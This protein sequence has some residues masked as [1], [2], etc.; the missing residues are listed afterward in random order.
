MPTNRK[1]FMETLST[2]M[3]EPNHCLELKEKTINAR[4]IKV[5]G[6][7]YL[8]DD[9]NIYEKNNDVWTEMDPGHPDYISIISKIAK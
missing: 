9:N 5:E 3:N 6:M 7:S 8:Y 4:E 2:D 1:L